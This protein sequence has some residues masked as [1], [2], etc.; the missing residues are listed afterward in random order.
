MERKEGKRRDQGLEDAGEEAGH[1]SKG[2]VC[3]SGQSRSS[4]SAFNWVGSEQTPCSWVLVSPIHREENKQVPRTSWTEP[5]R[6]PKVPHH[7]VDGRTKGRR[8]CISERPMI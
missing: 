3:R 8:G 2:G 5:W 1:W 6:A 4:S 7:F